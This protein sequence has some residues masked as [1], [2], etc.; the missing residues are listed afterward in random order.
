MNQLAGK[1]DPMKGVRIGA[2]VAA[3]VV[4]L[5]TA[6]AAQSQ[7]DGRARLVAGDCAPTLADRAVSVF[8][9]GAYAGVNHEVQ[10]RVIALGDVSVDAMQ[11]GTALAPNP[12]RDDLIAGGAIQAN[13]TQVPNGSATYGTTFGGQLIAPVGTVTRAPA[14]A[15]LDDVYATTGELSEAWA[16]LAANGTI[17]GP[18]Y[19]QLQF[20]GE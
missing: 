11:I 8:T 6:V 1:L 10:G 2:L 16:L 4:L 17:E 12:D 14:S 20:V 9:S 13:G 19:G 7:S 3:L 15:G 5:A 18:T